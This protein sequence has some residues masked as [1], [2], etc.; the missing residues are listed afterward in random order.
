MSSNRGKFIPLGIF[1]SSIF[2]FVLL[3]QLAV[4]GYLYRHISYPLGIHLFQCLAGIPG[5]ALLLAIKSKDT[6]LRKFIIGGAGVWLYF[7]I[8][9]YLFI[10]WD[11]LRY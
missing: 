4:R 7:W 9:Y 2:V 10:L 5:I 6:F 1:V 3:D 8:T 11:C